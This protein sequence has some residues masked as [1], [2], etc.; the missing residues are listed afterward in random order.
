MAGKDNPFPKSGDTL[1]DGKALIGDT[2]PI[3]AMLHRA[4]EKIFKTEYNVVSQ[5]Y[6][7]KDADLDYEELH[8]IAGRRMFQF[9]TFHSWKSFAQKHS[10]SLSGRI[11]G[12][13]VALYAGTP[14]ILIAVDKR[15]EELGQ[16]LGIPLVTK[17][18]LPKIKSVSDLKQVWS[19]S[20]I[21]ELYDAHYRRFVGYLDEQKLNHWQ[22]SAKSSAS[23]YYDEMLGAGL[24]N[25]TSGTITVLHAK[26]G[27]IGRGCKTML[28]RAKVETSARR[29]LARVKNTIKALIK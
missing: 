28:L 27:I 23:A 5:S 22:R 20:R 3:R 14:A 7:G 11:H 19:E 13:V 2:P 26:R 29:M 16:H 6:V 12:S 18:Q 1:K 25:A 8:A 15:T 17:E 9:S 24:T 4:S 21:Q 10:I